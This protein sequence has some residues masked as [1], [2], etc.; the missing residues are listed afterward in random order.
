MGIVNMLFILM[1]ALLA[2][3]EANRVWKVRRSKNGIVWHTTYTRFGSIKVLPA[4]GKWVTS[5]RSRAKHF[6]W[7][8]PW[9]TVRLYKQSGGG[10]WTRCVRK[11]WNLAGHLKTVTYSYSKS[12]RCTL[13]WKFPTGNSVGSW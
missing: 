3:V 7:G 10:T 13:G 11:Y 1:I 4:S 6:F 2:I 9:G 8:F 12:G 5:F